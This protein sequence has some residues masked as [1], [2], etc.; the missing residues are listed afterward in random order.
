MA[1]YNASWLYRVKVTVLATKVDVDC[2]DFPVYVNLNNLPAGFHTHCNQTDCRDIRV[3]TSDEVTEVPREVVFYT[4]A[5]DTGE[6][7][8]K[9]NIDSDTDT[10]FY[11]YYGNA[12]ATEPAA[13]ATYGKYN[14]WNSNYKAVW[15]LPNGSSLTTT[16]STSNQ[17]T[18]T[19]ANASAHAGKITG[20][21]DLTGSSS[22]ISTSGAAAITSNKLTVSC[23][24][25]PDVTTR[26][27]LVTRWGNGGDAQSQFDLL[28]GITSAKPTFYIGPTPAGTPQ[29]AG[30]GATT[31]AT[32]G[33]WYYVVGTYSGT[34]TAI[35]LNGVLQNSATINL[36]M[37]TTSLK[38][39]EIG[40]NIGADGCYNGKIDEVRIQDINRAVEWLTTEYNNQNSPS[41]FYSLGAET[42]NSKNSQ[43]NIGDAWK[44]I[45]GFQ[46]NI[47]DAWKT[48]TKMQINIGDVWKSIF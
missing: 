21:A 17:V 15:H 20:G 4:A 28:Y 37:P 34:V 13:N 8:F 25:A 46:I 40:D 31:M 14:T 22:H 11:I 24:V 45:T 32:D 16:D 33:T 6:L 47:G 1:W 44:T 39:Y 43:I 38:D 48:V 12:A 3:T 2:T 23:W 19:A 26:G 18:G 41:T 10:D 35:Y 27:D 30:V 29:P 9:G 36:T 5:S 42:G 7:Y